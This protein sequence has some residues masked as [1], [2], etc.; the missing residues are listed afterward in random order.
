[1]AGIQLPG[2]G[3]GFPIQS[4]VDATVQAERAPK[5]NALNRKQESLDVRISSYASLK[6]ELDAFQK[7]L[8]DL[9]SKEA[10]QKR[11]VTLSNEGFFTAKA[12]KNAVAG[13]YTLKVEQLAQAHKVGSGYVSGDIKD[14]L[15]AGSITLGMGAESFT[16]DVTADKSSLADIAKAINQSDDN[17]GVSATVVTDDNGPRLVLFGDKTGQENQI[18]V[19][20]S[21][22]AG[23]TDI[24]S[25]ANMKPVQA[26]QDAIVNIDGATVTRSSNEIK[27]AI[28]GVTLNLDKLNNTDDPTT[29]LTIGY[30]KESVTENL[31]KFVESYNKIISTTK[32]LTSFDPESKAAGPLNGDTLV[33]NITSEL[34]NALGAEVEGASSSLKSLSD[35]GIT[36]KRDG[37]LEIDNDVL[38]EHIANNF[39]GIG[40]LFDGDS[41]LA[42]KLDEMLEGFTGREG[43]LTTKDES[44]NSQL[45]KLNKQR[46]D[47]E[48][49]MLKFEDRVFRQY[50]AMDQMIAD[51]NNQMNSMMSMLGT[52]G[53]L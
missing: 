3:S 49:R 19:S 4:F 52:G 40:R 26:A 6:K 47:F 37:T 28:A 33:R 43:I 7:S 18:S 24:F 17:T 34:R 8:K 44:L 10:F 11:S 21:G 31:K 15:G 12:D 46:A 1:M 23:L 50:N 5:E 42:S 14:N 2:V 20:A 22:D 36:T 25:S 32:K 38:D 16:V 53:M 51:M 39:D 41:G 13:S 48:D 9:T 30:D 29:K 45:S 27:D 35:L